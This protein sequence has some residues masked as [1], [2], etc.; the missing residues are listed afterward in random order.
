[1]SIKT[2]VLF[3]FLIIATAIVSCSKEEKDLDQELKSLIANNAQ[4][5]QLEYYI[6]PESTDYNSLPNQEPQNPITKEKIELGKLLFFEPGLA[7]KA[8]HDNCIETYSCSSCHVPSKA[9]LPG[10]IQGIADGA[11]GFGDQGSTR[12]LASG[13]LESEIDA[14]GNRPL[15]VMNVTYVTNTLWSGLFG[16]NDRNVGTEDNWVGLAEVNHTGYAGLEAQN[17]EGFDLH[18]LDINDRVLYEFG[19]DKLFD[20]AF[21]DFPIE[22]RYT[23]VT[24]SFAMGAYLRSLLTNEAPFQKYLKG[25]D[26]AISDSEKEGAILFFSKAGCSSCHNSPSFSA[27]NFFA[28]GTKDMYELG[29]LNTSADDPRILGRGLF[30]GE[31]EDMF[32]FKVPQLYN[33]KDYVSYFHGSS[34]TSIE[35]V[36]DFKLAAKTENPKVKQSEV[37][38]SPKTL[39]E[40]EKS[41]LISFLKYSLHDDNMERYMPE[42]VL[43]GFCFPNNDEV[44]REDMGCN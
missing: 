29:G 16:A 3:S 10:R 41:N 7:Q 6:M 42:S 19:Y 28:L 26:L 9:F 15:T 34:K 14:Q 35:D 13:Y 2:L 23:P 39:T 38:I 30:T 22:E 18:R 8:L 43:S 27:M 40:E 5:G 33:L 44:A 1:M 37:Q 31:E 24:A 21:P 32:K 17:I 12:T 25:N 20:K 11:V 4:D 36:V